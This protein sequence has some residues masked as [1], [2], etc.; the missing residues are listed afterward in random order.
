MPS[1]PT[2]HTCF[3]H[4]SRPLCVLARVDQRTPSH[5]PAS[6]SPLSRTRSMAAV[7][8]VQMQHD[9]GAPEEMK[10]N[11]LKL[12]DEHIRGFSEMPTVDEI[13]Q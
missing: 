3:T 6:P 1:P 9:A 7:L 4:A 5:T 8:H 11:F 13:Y 10:A 2:L 12:S